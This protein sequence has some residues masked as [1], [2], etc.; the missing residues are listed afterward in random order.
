MC[1]AFCADEKEG[2]RAPGWP[3]V[4][5]CASGEWCAAAVS[6]AAVLSMKGLVVW[7]PAF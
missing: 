4:W 2:W 7:L 1:E 6:Q 3:I 5:I